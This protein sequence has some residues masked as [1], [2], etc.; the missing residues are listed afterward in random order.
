MQVTVSARVKDARMG[1]ALWCD[2]GK[3][4]FS[5]KADNMTGTRTV[6]RDGKREVEDYLI[7]S[8]C[9]SRKTNIPAIE[10]IPFEEDD[11]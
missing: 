11:V 9:M 6:T 8:D 5:E 10:N 4:A 1:F 7:C 2:E 3:H